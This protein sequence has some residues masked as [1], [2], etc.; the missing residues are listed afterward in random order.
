M[1]QN[2]HSDGD[3]QNEIEIERAII[4]GLAYL[5]TEGRDGS[6][7]SYITDS[8][9]VEGTIP[10]PAEIFTS[11]LVADT[12]P[13]RSPFSSLTASCLH[14]VR[15][16]MP[17]YPLSFF[18]DRRFPPPDSDTNS[19]ATSVLLENH[20]IDSRTANHI[21]DIILSFRDQQ[22]RVQVWLSDEMPCELDDVVGANVLYLGY[23]L[24]RGGEMK[25]TEDW[26]MERLDSYVY[27]LEGTRY[28]PSPDSF[29]YFLGRLMKFR[30]MKNKL[31]NKLANHVQQRIGTTEYP[32]DI[33]IRSIVATSLGI[34][35][36]EEMHKLLCMQGLD[37]A[38]PTDA[39]YSEGKQVVLYS[40][41]Y[42]NKSLPTVFSIRALELGFEKK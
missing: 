36:E 20:L 12:L 38:W 41:Y 23:L 22:G 28:Y 17:P 10:V 11:V 4:S 39:L 35:N 32:L 27:L 15:N 42:G 31:H 37:G 18:E 16:Q 26:I 9:E 25:K 19:L 13:K 40:T 6:Y 3:E 7:T 30:E 1:S 5:E 24:G 33:A 2:K 8:R 14:Y 21:L 29:L 34:H